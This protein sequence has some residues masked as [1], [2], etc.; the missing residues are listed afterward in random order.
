M[1]SARLLAAPF[2]T[3][4][5]T[6]IATPPAGARRVAPVPLGPQD[7]QGNWLGPD[8]TTLLTA[9]LPSSG[10][11]MTP[12]MTGGPTIWGS[13]VFAPHCGATVFLRG[14]ITQRVERSSEEPVTGHYRSGGLNIAITDVGFDS[15]G[16]I[17]GQAHLWLP[18]GATTATTARHVVVDA[19][20]S[21]VSGPCAKA[22]ERKAK[23]VI[24]TA[25]RTIQQAPPPE[26][27]TPAT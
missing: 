13:G 9:Q 18:P 19:Y 12:D 15:T 1:V 10:T 17:A 3:V 8:I 21:T 7:A 24:Q 25:L 16:A 20:T 6:V 2:A 4:F 22:I 27:S 23:R 11:L 5:A 26:T 14:S